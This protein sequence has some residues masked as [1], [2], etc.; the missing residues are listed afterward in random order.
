MR[1]NTSLLLSQRFSMEARDIT[2]ERSHPPL[3]PHHRDGGNARKMFRCASSHEQRINT[4]RQETLFDR[5][6]L[7]GRFRHETG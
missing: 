1:R 4:D 3:D 2:P 5:T 6:P 7:S